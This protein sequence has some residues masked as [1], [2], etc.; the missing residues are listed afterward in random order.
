M[1]WLLIFNLWVTDLSNP[2]PTPYPS[3]TECVEA[4]KKI[5]GEYKW[6]Y[7]LEIGPD[8]LKVEP[9]V[10]RSTVRCE[11]AEWTK[12]PKGYPKGFPKGSR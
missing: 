11:P 2:P 9:G 6:L 7:Y 8:T 4:A 12:N 5:A 10:F 1:E 3:R